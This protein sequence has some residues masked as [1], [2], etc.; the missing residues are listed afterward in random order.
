M[1]NTCVCAEG[2]GSDIQGDPICLSNNKLIKS[3]PLFMLKLLGNI[4]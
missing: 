2:A 1:Y 4:W 3:L